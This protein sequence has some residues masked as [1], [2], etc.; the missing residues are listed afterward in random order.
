MRT[1]AAGSSWRRCR[2]ARGFTLLE[3]LLVLALMALTTT[4]VTLAWRDTADDVLNEEAVRLST[5]LEVARARSRASN[6]PVLWQLREAGFEFVGSPAQPLS[7]RWL[8]AGVR[9][10]VQGTLVLG[11]EPL[12]SPARIALHHASGMTLWVVSDGLRPFRVV[13]SEPGA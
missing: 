3:L 12:I 5:L 2:P 4:G 8:S 1:S 7:G 10:E 6:V 11:P 9:A 13:R